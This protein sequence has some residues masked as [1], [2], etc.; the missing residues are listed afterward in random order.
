MRWPPKKVIMAIVIIAII[1]L[2]WSGRSMRAASTEFLT[3][4][5]WIDRITENPREL[6]ELVLLSD[7]SDFGITGAVSRY[8][9]TFDL[10]QWTLDGD[11]LTIHQL[12]ED[13][14]TTYGV[15]TW[16]CQPG[17]SPHEDLEY[18]MSLT[19]PSGT[20]KYYAGDREED[21]LERLLRDAQSN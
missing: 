13:R 9:L 19:G 11:R 5:V 7:E 14:R 16:R 4:R 10:A 12:Q 20:K 18:C 1:L 15:K 21:A 8:R 3:E 6:A 17:E 2:I